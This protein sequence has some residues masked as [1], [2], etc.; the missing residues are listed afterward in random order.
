MSLGSNLKSIRDNE[1]AGV[2]DLLLKEGPHGV[3]WIQRLLR[4]ATELGMTINESQQ[5]YYQTVALMQNCV[6]Q[7]PPPLP[8]K[9]FFPIY[10]Q[11]IVYPLRDPEVIASTGSK[12]QKHITVFHRLLNTT[13]NHIY[14][15][16]IKK[17]NNIITQAKNDYKFWRPNSPSNNQRNTHVPKHIRL[18]N[19]KT[20]KEALRRH[21]MYVF[22]LA[23]INGFDNG[24]GSKPEKT[25]RLLCNAG[26]IVSSSG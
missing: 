14:R 4:S 13:H 9:F 10:L 26:C 1:V 19:F 21:G 18:D 23:E 8:P 24:S 2:I 7:N 12:K 16:A 3:T 15:L 5:L 20:I 17:V 25:T 22:P 6:Y 11:I